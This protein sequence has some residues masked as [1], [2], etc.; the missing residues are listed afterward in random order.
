M[1]LANDKVAHPGDREPVLQGALGDRYDHSRRYSVVTYHK[2][3]ERVSRGWRI[4]CNYPSSHP[5]E[6][7]VVISYGPTPM[8]YLEPIELV[9]PVPTPSS[10]QMGWLRAWLRRPR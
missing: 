8:P 4:E 1:P 7:L 10:S 3:F 5:N 9:F 2:A 6:K